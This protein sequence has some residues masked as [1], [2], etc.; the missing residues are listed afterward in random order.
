MK[1]KV[2]T[3]STIL[4]L[5]ISMLQLLTGCGSKAEKWAYDY[6]PDKEVISFYDNGKCVYKGDKYT[7][8]RDGSNI[9]LTDIWGKE[10]TL[11]Y[12]NENGS[13]I[14]Y[15]KSTY[16]YDGDNS[17]NGL[18]GIWKQDNG[19]SYQ[20]TEDGKFSE[21]NIF[22]GHYTVDES[23]HCIKLMYDDPID[24]AYLYYSVDGNELTIDYPWPMVKMN[25]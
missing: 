14:L 16:T 1:K 13:I 10:Q 17:T 2:R 20:F 11:R 19:W 9:R 5:M 22:F 6:A 12:V 8:T 21:E 15:E 4:I 24:D 23:T 3:I 7:F 25:S 18:T